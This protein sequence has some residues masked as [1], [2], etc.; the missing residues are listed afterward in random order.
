MKA[1]LVFFSTDV[2]KFLS[3]IENLK[4][5]NFWHNDIY[6]Y[7]FSLASQ[8]ISTHFSHPPPP[9]TRDT[10]VYFQRKQSCANFFF[11]ALLNGINSSKK[12]FAPK[13]QI[14]SF[15]SRSHF[16]RAIQ[17]SKQEVTKVGSLCNKP[18]TGMSCL[19]LHFHKTERVSELRFNVSPT[20]R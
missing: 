7:S 16:R 1:I 12:E 19:T 17:E 11:A 18:Q 13:E 5:V 10:V 2:R 14:L 15:K 20:T 6:F 9:P 4:H 8:F 3:I